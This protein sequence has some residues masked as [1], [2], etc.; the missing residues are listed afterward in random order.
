MKSLADTTLNTEDDTIFD[1][2]TVTSVNTAAESYSVSGTSLSAPKSRAAPRHRTTDRRKM[3]SAYQDKK[4]V[5]WKES[6]ENATTAVNYDGAGRHWDYERGWVRAD[7]TADDDVSE[8][9]R[10]TLEGAQQVD[11]GRNIAITPV[12]KMESKEIVVNNSHNASNI[13]AVEESVPMSQ[14]P[15]VVE[16]VLDD[17]HSASEEANI[18]KENDSYFLI[19]GFV[20]GSLKI[21]D[22]DLNVIKSDSNTR[23]GIIRAIT[24]SMINENELI[25]VSAGGDNLLQLWK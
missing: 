9:T 24:S 16:E 23:K 2:M 4:P 7:G 13:A 1:S 10:S 5:G 12:T 20:D 19:V 17:A 11:Q 21:F 15:P 6:M 14:L 3:A 8:L 25:I 22:M 18:F